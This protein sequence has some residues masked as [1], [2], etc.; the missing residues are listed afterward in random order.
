MLYRGNLDC[1]SITRKVLP[2][3]TK[4]SPI[5]Q[6]YPL[7]NHS[8]VLHGHSA[9]NRLLFKKQIILRYT[10]ISQILTCSHPGSFNTWSSHFTSPFSQ[11]PFACPC[12]WKWKYLL[13][14]C[15]FNKRIRLAQTCFVLILS[16]K[17]PVASKGWIKCQLS[18]GKG[19]NFITSSCLTLRLFQNVKTIK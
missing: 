8:T 3:S 17:L 14:L 10:A 9:G 2:A 7:S 11:N 16:L 4:P 6:G 5:L 18:S 13:T 1:F 15:L 19:I 12:T